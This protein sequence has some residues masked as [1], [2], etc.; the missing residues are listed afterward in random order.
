MNIC[1]ESL[2]GWN[3][4]GFITRQG[5]PRT[6]LAMLTA[7][8]LIVVFLVAIVGRWHAK[9]P[10]GKVWRDLPGPWALPL[11]GNLSYM[12]HPDLPVRFLELAHRYGPIYRLR[13][14]KKGKLLDL[15]NG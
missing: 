12:F 3:G 1:Y 13:F 10:R 2:P 8:L 4:P 5:P 11:I 14:G 6:H 7:A 9:L 15:T